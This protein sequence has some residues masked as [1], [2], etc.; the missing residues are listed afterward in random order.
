MNMKLFAKVEYLNAGWDSDK[1]DIK[2]LDSAKM[3]E[4]DYVSMGQSYTSVY[5]KDVKGC[6]NSVNFEFYNKDGEQVNIFSMPE[7]NPYL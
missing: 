2:A 1:K 4:V 6:F 7:Y 5:L 3:Y